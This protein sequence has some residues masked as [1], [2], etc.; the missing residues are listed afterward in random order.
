MP[1]AIVSLLYLQ[2]LELVLSPC[3]LPSWTEVVPPPPLA[4]RIALGLMHATPVAT[5]FH[6]PGAGT[7]WEGSEGEPLWKRRKVL[8]GLVTRARMILPAR[9]LSDNGLRPGRRRCKVRTP[10]AVPIPC[11]PPQVPPRLNPF[12]SFGHSLGPAEAPWIDVGLSARRITTCPPMCMT[13]RFRGMV[14]PCGGALV[15]CAWVTS[16]SDVVLR[17]AIL[18]RIRTAIFLWFCI[19]QGM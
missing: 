2:P 6:R 17:L 5:L 9:R 12:G 8:E 10:Q 16:G 13:R 1:H 3:R 7:R 14:G 4:Q 11:R 15:G 19:R 18:C